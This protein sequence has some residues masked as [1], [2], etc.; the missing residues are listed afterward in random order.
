MT[1]LS[2]NA[3]R[4]VIAI[5]AA[6]LIVAL[7]VPVLRYSDRWWNGVPVHWIAGRGESRT[8][9][10]EDGI[11]VQLDAD[12]ELIVK[13]GEALFT[14]AHDVS[15]PFELEA[16]PGRIIDLGTRFDVEALRD[17][18]RVVV[19]QGQLGIRTHRGEEVLTAGRSGGYDSSGVL[20]PI[21]KADASAALWTTGERYFDGEPLSEVIERLNR[22]HDVTFVFTDPQLKELQVSGTFRMSDLP[23]F[24]RTLA[25]VFPVTAK[26]VDTQHVELA[27]RTATNS[28][29]PRNGTDAGREL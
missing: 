7:V 12:S 3:K 11:R 13:F 29:D 16:G 22:Y 14:V 17:S 6:L 25:T 8:L 20:L 1:R 24:L 15:H 26:W 10:L 9:A 5:C 2:A 27:W 21:R 4:Q 18:T 23:L 19:F 28:Q